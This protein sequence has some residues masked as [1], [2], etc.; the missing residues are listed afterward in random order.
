MSAMITGLPA[1]EGFPKRFPHKKVVSC[2][3]ANL[4]GAG[5]VSRSFDWNGENFC[6]KV[7]SRAAW[8]RQNAPAAISAASA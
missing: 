6:K 8:I 4:Q 3:R 2:G 7:A 5:V 1:R